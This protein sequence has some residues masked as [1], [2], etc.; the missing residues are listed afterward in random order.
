MEYKYFIS[1]A[2][3]VRNQ[4]AGYGDCVITQNRPLSAAEDIT[5]IREKLL[6][7]SPDWSGVTILNWMRLEEE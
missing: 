6:E 2:F 3:F 1:Y 7:E 5:Q 4:W